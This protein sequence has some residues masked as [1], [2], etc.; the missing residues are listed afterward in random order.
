METLD[1]STMGEVKDPPLK[2]WEQ[3]KSYKFPNFQLSARY[4]H[5]RQEV[6]RRVMFFSAAVFLAAVFTAI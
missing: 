6:E 4:A 5:L 3:F 2:R 1:Y